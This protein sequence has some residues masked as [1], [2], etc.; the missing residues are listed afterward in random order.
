MYL[1]TSEAQK[2]LQ[3]AQAKAQQMGVKVSISVVDGRGDLLAMVR[4]DG[5]SWRTAGI[6]KGK[7]YASANFGVASAELTARATSPVMQ[8]FLMSVHGECVPAQGAV[9][10][11]RDGRV[12]G[13][14][15]VSGAKS[16]ED[17]EIAK[18]GVAT[19]QK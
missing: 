6:S 12:L 9:P 16:E 14:V 2:M 1:N 4:L 18:A 3:A 8:S 7:A 11:M 17:E 5:A 15:G 10:A 13:A 19:L